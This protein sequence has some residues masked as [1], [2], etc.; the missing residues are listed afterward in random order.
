MNSINHENPRDEKKTTVFKAGMKVLREK[1]VSKTSMNDIIRE[2]GLSKGGVYHYFP[3]KNDLLV[4]L[5]NYF[6][7]L[8]AISKFERM[9]DDNVTQNKSAIEQIDI[10]IQLHEASLDDMGEDMSLMMDLYIEA[11]H[12]PALRQV[13]NQQYQFV[14]T[15]VKTLIENAQ[16]QGDIK[17]D[18]NSTMISASLL[19]VFDG[20]GLAHQVVE[21]ANDY[22]RMALDAAR[23]ILAGAAS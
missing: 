17:A 5:F 11:I 9:Q 14:F 10:L 16:K 22:P 3:S 8:Y 12:N 13:F 19:A 2:S 21:D 15:I 20:F 6:F 1:G 23:L 7:E 18:L 4:E